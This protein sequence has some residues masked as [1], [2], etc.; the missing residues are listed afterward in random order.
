MLVAKALYENTSLSFK[1]LRDKT[2]L[3]TN[4][5]NHVLIEM[6]G[7]D[8]VVQVDGEYYLTEYSAILLGAINQMREEISRVPERKLFWPIS[9]I[10]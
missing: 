9:K 5:L 2:G 4:I 10:I 1:D 7:T 8:L 6:K 3:S